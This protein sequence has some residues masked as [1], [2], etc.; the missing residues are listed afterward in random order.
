MVLLCVLIAILVIV[1]GPV[2]DMILKG[3]QKEWASENEREW[4]RIK[5]QIY[6]SREAAKALTI[7]RNEDN[8]KDAFRSP[9]FN[10]STRQPQPKSLEINSATAQQWSSIRGIG[11]V[12]SDR[13]V[14][15]RKRLGGFHSVGQLKEV[16]GISDSLYTAIK[17]MLKVD[18]GKLIQM[19]PNSADF[20][21]L[22]AHPY[23]S[24][25]IAKQMIGYRT[26]VATFET[27]ED[28]Q[29]LYGM[30]DTLYQKLLPYFKLGE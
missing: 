27:L 20:E 26:K 30:N 5:N 7:S 17:P 25:T 16:Y 3:K 6:Q 24:K 12:L 23:I 2:Y 22:S 14:K 9:G 29:K 19:D 18:K 13:I 10:N 8:K 1:R 15:Y 28:L 11:P 21:S 4:Q